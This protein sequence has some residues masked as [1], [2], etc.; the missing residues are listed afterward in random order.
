VLSIPNPQVASSVPANHRFRSGQPLSLG[1][2][3]ADLQPTAVAELLP[4]ASLAASAAD[5]GSS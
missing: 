2:G 5:R 3:L 4:L 1:L